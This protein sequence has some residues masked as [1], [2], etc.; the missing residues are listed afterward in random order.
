MKELTKGESEIMQILWHIK[1]G[2]VKDILAEIPEPKPSYNT[3]STIVR[4]LEDKGFVKHEAFGKTHQYFPVVNKARYRQFIFKKMMG[5]Y[6]DGSY[7]KLA[8]F[9]MEDKEMDEKELQE[10]IEILNKSKEKK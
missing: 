7:K 9:F 4:I 8:S 2:F 1:K 5:E 6:F 10:I 3:V